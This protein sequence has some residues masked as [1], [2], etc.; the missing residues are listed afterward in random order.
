MQQLAKKWSDTTLWN[1][2]ISRTTACKKK[3][4]LWYNFPKKGPNAKSDDV[5]NLRLQLAKISDQTCKNMIENENLQQKITVN[6]YLQQ[7]WFH[8]TIC[9]KLSSPTI[10]KRWIQTYLGK[11][12]WL[13]TW[14]RFNHSLLLTYQILYFTNYRTF[15]CLD[16]A[17]FL[18]LTDVLI[19]HSSC[20]PA[21]NERFR[22]TP[23]FPRNLY[24]H[25]RWILW[26]KVV[27]IGY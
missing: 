2:T 5:W 13:L 16:F 8:T 18:N 3:M 14:E 9:K 4:N 25:Q 23:Q 17:I 10:G 27:N 24:P 26:L 15:F 20:W 21:W 1:K 22:I 12:R 11:H 7:N 6:K 19:A